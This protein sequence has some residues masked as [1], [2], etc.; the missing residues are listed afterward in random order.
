M[1]Q[2]S[3]LDYAKAIQ[4]QLSSVLNPSPVYSNF[5]RN[6]ASQPKFATWN[7]RNVHQPVFAG[8]LQNNKGIDTPI[9][10]VVC[11]AQTTEDAFTMAQAV[12]DALHG[13]SGVFGGAS[14]F[15]VGKI[16]VSWVYN[17]YDNDTKMA[18]VNLDCMMY[19]A[20]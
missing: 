3:V 5:N 18:Q 13:Y 12:I 2:N 10:Q 19:V 11:F 9:F 1:G 14:G 16:D 8:T 20:S 4:Y 15:A 6:W 17:T 7:L